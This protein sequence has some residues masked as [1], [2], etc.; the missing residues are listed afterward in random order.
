VDVNTSDLSRSFTRLFS[1]LVDGALATGGYMLNRGDAGLLRS[2]EKLSAA[3]AS[4]S[5]A[6][7]ATIAGHAEHLRYSL[8]LMNRWAGGEKD[9]WTGADWRAA[10][11]T[12]SV[13]DAEWQAL[14]SALASEAH[15]WLDA[16]GR[17]REVTKRELNGIMGSIAH[18]AYHLGA[19][20]QVAQ[21]ASG[22]PATG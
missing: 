1:E 19:I 3:E 20:R 9:P 4:A 12:T 2:L 6:G 15:R 5:S 18:L 17:P 21:A 14:R 22:P 13:T 11:Q 16:M 10:W 7:G 8:S